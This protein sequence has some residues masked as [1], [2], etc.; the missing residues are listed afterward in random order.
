MLEADAALM[1]KLDARSGGGIGAVEFE[2]G[3]PFGL[4]KN[5]KA[6]IH[7]DPRSLSGIWGVGS[8]LCDA[9]LI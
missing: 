7:R 6:N 4:K 3:K 5:V 2:D 8:Q 9:G 1:E